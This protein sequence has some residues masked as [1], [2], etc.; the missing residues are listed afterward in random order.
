MSKDMPAP[1]TKSAVERAHV[2]IERAE[3][4][5]EPLEDPLL[6]FSVL[7]GFWVANYVA[8]NGDLMR[9]LAAQFLVARRE[10]KGNSA[11]DDRAS[12]RRHNLVVHGRLRAKRGCIWIKRSRFTTL[13][14]IARWPRVLATDAAGISL[15]LSI[16][17][18]MV[19]WAIPTLHL[20]TQSV[21]SRTREK[22]A[23]RPR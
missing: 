4:L 2:L 14:S 6:L 22:S 18:P 10:T 7:Y 23:K 3:A 13:S 12:Y 17:G 16:D 20:R 19:H 11:N 15:I 1:E 5:G 9:E 21:P 8:F